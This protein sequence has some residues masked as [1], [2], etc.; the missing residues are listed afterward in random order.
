MEAIQENHST[1]KPEL[2]IEIPVLT[3]TDIQIPEEIKQETIE[4]TIEEIK[5][6]VKTLIST[7]DAIVDQVY[8]QL[9]ESKDKLKSASAFD[10]II[11]SMELVETGLVA[12]INKKEVVVAVLERISKG[13]DGIE[14]TSDDLISQDTIKMIKS[15]LDNALIEGVIDTIVKASKKLFNINKNKKWWCCF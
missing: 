1:Q 3:P 12:H 6:D 10:I 13:F 8:K 9:F 2:T 15:L 5:Q 14:G 4:E 7:K 11:M